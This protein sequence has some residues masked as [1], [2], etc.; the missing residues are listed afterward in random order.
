MGITFKEEVTMGE[1]ASQKIFK[2]LSKV[3]LWIW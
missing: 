2:V 1:N 3:S